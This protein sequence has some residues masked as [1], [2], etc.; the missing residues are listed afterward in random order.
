MTAAVLLIHAFFV[1]MVTGI[2]VEQAGESVGIKRGGDV[3]ERHG[4]G[5]KDGVEVYAR[6]IELQQTYVKKTLF[7]F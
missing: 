3:A 7:N 5:E 1:A 4:N 6:E 2:M